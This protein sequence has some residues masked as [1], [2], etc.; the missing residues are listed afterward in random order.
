MEPGDALFIPDSWWHVIHSKRPDDV[1]TDAGSGNIGVAFE[2]EG[3]GNLALDWPA[4][5]TPP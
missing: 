4:K 2:L 5:V 3:F 1:A